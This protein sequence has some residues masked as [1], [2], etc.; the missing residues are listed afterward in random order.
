MV[1]PLKDC[2][3]VSLE[4]GQLVGSG[5]EVSDALGRKE[6]T[7]HKPAPDEATTPKQGKALMRTSMSVEISQQ[8]YS[9]GG[10]R[11]LSYMAMRRPSREWGLTSTS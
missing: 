8:A 6:V 7:I 4:E 3:L 2:S 5:Q 1:C 9:T 10:E 11:G